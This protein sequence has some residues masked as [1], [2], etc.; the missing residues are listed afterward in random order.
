[1]DGVLIDSS[2]TQELTVEGLTNG[3]EYCFQITANYEEGES[4]QSTVVC[5][6]PLAISDWAFKFKF[7]R[8]SAGIL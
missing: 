5:A 4:E 1:M 2:E 3:T 6:T 8:I 7:C